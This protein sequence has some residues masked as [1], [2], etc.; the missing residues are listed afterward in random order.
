VIKMVE[1]PEC[2]THNTESQGSEQ[3]YR[4]QDQ[5]QTVVETEYVCNICGCEFTLR[6]VTSR[7]TKITIRGFFNTER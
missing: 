3:K 1:C 7:T 5:F 6:E 2:G 4:E